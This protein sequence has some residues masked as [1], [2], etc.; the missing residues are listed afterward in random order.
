M[1][2]PRTS[3]FAVLIWSVPVVV[4]FA[5][6]T[7]WFIVPSIVEKNTREDALRSSS[8][9]VRQFKTLR[10]YYTK[11]VVKKVL[12]ESEIKPST[13]HATTSNA[14][15]LP[16]TLIHD[17]SN[18]LKEQDT[19]ISLYSPYPFPGRADRILDEFQMAAWDYLTVNPEGV[20]SE[21]TVR[22]GQ[23]VLRV[24]SADTMAA[25]ACVGCHNSRPDTPKND[26]QLGDV[27]G[28]LEVTKN[29][30][31][32]LAA[33][34][35]L[36][37][38][39]LALLIGIGITLACTTFYF[40]RKVVT[41]V[42][43]ITKTMDI[44]SQG[45]TDLEKLEI[46]GTDKEDEIGKIARSLMVFKSSRLEKRALEE[47]KKEV[48]KLAEERRKEEEIQREEFLKEKEQNDRQAETE[49]QQALLDLVTSFESSVGSVVESVATAATEMQATAETM[50]DISDQ[51]T[52]QADTV[53]HASTGATK[54]VQSVASAAEQLSASIREIS[55]Q[56]SQSSNITNQAVSEAGKADVLIKGLDTGA[57]NI[58]EVVSL[59]QDIAEQTNLLALNA[60]IEAARAGEAG[61]GFAV[62]ASE[63]KNLASQTAKA[64][65]QISSQ[66]SDV[67]SS[68][69]NAVDAI[70]GIS[71]TIQKVDEIAAAIASAV[72]QQ[73][74]ATQ[75]ISLSVQKAAE[76]TEAVSS[77]I[78]M[79]TQAATQSNDV[80]NSVLKASEKLSNEA[81]NLRSQVSS[82]VQDVKTG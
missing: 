38:T 15:P 81:E 51:T 13:E 57:Q 5:M 47:E 68:T 4:C 80:S 23:R 69:S 32:Q 43:S 7:V 39:I 25:D 6:L 8:E 58:G 24:A 62:V 66:I 40:S 56:V 49:K 26:W 22:D 46:V 21:E 65:E 27:R 37:L 78:Q 33:G 11:N 44:L 29:I 77:S 36:S 71:Q 60:T 82:F 48:S 16:A 64:T 35:T 52:S 76:G 17:M 3:I 54:N 55:Q 9:T 74:A 79:V 73:G 59:I 2:N 70:Q 41:K 18:L 34:K 14:I 20:Y 50:S 45:T 30:E 28:V 31:P 12:A 53:S 75:E 1:L 67:Q 42:N 63:V 61:K 10:G 72:E 19:T